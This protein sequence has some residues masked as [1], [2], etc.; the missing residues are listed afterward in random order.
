MSDESIVV[1]GR[2][3]ITFYEANG[4]N[5]NPEPSAYSFDL[6]LNLMDNFSFPT[7]EYRVT[8]ASSVDQNGVF[9]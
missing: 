2:R 9:G 7:I 1:F 6:D 8:D 3:V 4:L 5:V